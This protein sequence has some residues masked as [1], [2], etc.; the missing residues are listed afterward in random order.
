MSDIKGSI[1]KAAKAITKGSGTLIKT[2]KLTINLS[3]EESKLK[4]IYAEIGKSVHEI[5][6]HGG[7]LGALFDQ[8]YQEILEAEAKISDIRNRLE[9]AK[10]TVTCSRCKATSKRGSAFCQK[11]GENLL[12]TRD[13]ILETRGE[14]P[15][16]Q[17][18]PPV[19][20]VE[21]AA[22]ICNICGANNDANDRFCL[23]CG[24]IMN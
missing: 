3:N 16:A 18:A 19:V 24:R 21:A 23:S 2:T 12:E 9:I 20:S 11:C 10:G 13:E 22:K 5:Y 17:V 6:K 14:L 8:K 1:G 15:S 7:S 4:G